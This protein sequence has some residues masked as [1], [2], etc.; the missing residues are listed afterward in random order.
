MSPELGAGMLPWTEASSILRSHLMIITTLLVGSAFFSGSE[1]ALF[2]LDR[3]AIE[4]ISEFS[5]ARGRTLQ[6]LLDEPRRLL[7]TL[8]LGNECINVCISAVGAHLVFSLWVDPNGAPW[9]VNILVITPVLLIC[10]EILPKVIAVRTAPTWSRLV[11]LPL[12]AFGF[13]VTPFRALLQFIADL[14]LGGL[15]E[16]ED[17]LRAAVK[18]GQFKALV[19][20]GEMQ[21]VLGASEAEMIH[22]VFDLSDTPVS[23]LMTSRAN[24]VSL[25]INSSLQEFLDSAM[26]PPHSR[27]PVYAGDPDSIRGILTTKDLLKFRGDEQSFS[28]RALIELLRPA[29]FVP[30]GKPADELMREFQ[31]TRGHMA[32]V[33]DEY[34][35]V[36]GIVTLQDILDE[37][38]TPFHGPRLDSLDGRARL[39]A[40]GD[41][42]FRVPARLEIS[43]WNQLMNP[44]LPQG[45]SFTTVAGYIFHLFGRLP[46]KGERAQND[47]WVFEVSGVE[48]TRLTQFTATR[49]AR[50]AAGGTKA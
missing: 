12:A 38:F 14:L 30:P 40:L 44:P 26:E 10:G 8:L 46:S 29:Y 15:V 47:N 7:A 22:R 20:L 36:Q 27:L 39:E 3:Y 49:K 6:R 31:Q 19:D 48:G 28:P 42:R 2:S 37:L 33:I 13:M 32:V 50:S 17:P 21:G 35:A 9:W 5:E 41:G 18:E 1:S 45:D 34:G 11:V 24:L 25:S 4:K 16:E 43:E 23:R